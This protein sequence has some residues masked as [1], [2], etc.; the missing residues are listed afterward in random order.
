MDRYVWVVTL[1]STLL[2]GSFMSFVQFLVTRHDERNRQLIPV[3][4]FNQLVSLTLAQVQARL[5]LRG[6]EFSRRG[7]L[8]ARERAMYREIYEKYHDLGG[9]HYAEDVYKEV[10]TLPVSDFGMNINK[11]ENH[12]DEY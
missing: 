11:G 12:Y 10:M 1:I 3:E 6:D 8:T 9:N 4:R 2:G 7:S 5:V